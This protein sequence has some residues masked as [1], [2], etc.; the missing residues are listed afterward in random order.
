MRVVGLDHVQLAM[1]AGSEAEARAFYAQVLGMREIPK[2]VKLASRGGV[3]FQCGSLQFHLGVEA[4]FRPTKKV[5]PALA[6]EGYAELLETLKGAGYEMIQ[7]TAL[8][9]VTRSFTFDPF[10]NRIEL[11]SADA[12]QTSL[13]ATP[14]GGAAELSTWTPP[15][16]ATV[17]ELSRK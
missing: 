7:D 6:I 10:G 2:P 15:F 14:K 17:L 1:P 4:D 11:I 3:W 9:A 16:K 5:H 12:P 8:L 13:Q